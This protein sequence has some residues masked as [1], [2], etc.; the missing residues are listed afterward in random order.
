MTTVEDWRRFAATYPR[1]RL[2]QGGL[3]AYERALAKVSP[4]DLMFAAR[5]FSAEVRAAGPNTRGW[6]YC[7]GPRTWLDEERWRAYLPGG[8]SH[9]DVSRSQ[10]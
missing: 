6:K 1:H 2:Q 8:S 4:S 9:I 7:P 5:R 10:Q 3:Q